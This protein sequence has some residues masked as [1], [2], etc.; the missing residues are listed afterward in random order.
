[1]QERGRKTVIKGLSDLTSRVILENCLTQGT[2]LSQSSYA[3][4]GPLSETEG[5]PFTHSL[6]HSLI[7]LLIHS[8]THSLTF[9]HFPTRKALWSTGV[10]SHGQTRHTNRGTGR[11]SPE[12]ALEEHKVSAVG[13][14]EG[15][16]HF[17]GRFRGKGN[18]SPHWLLLWTL[19][20]THSLSP[21]V[22]ISSL[23]T[24]E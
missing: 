23:I 5:H 7:H 13:N 10:L 17:H 2:Y 20:L 3:V 15:G 6:I 9:A 22:S 11:P 16:G 21:E 4:Y 8:L 14:L 12:R 1:M 24:D 19:S 18:N